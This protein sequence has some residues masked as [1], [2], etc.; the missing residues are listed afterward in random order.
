MAKSSDIIWVYR[1]WERNSWSA[2]SAERTNT[3]A[4][5]QSASR[6][7]GTKTGLVSPGDC[8]S[9]KTRKE[10]QM[11]S[12]VYRKKMRTTTVTAVFV[13]LWL[14]SQ[15]CLPGWRWAA[16]GFGDSGAAGR[17]EPS[18]SSAF[19]LL[20]L[21]W[22]RPAADNPPQICFL[23]KGTFIQ[24]RPLSGVRHVTVCMWCE[25]HNELAM[26]KY[27]WTSFFC[28]ILPLLS[29]T[30]I[31]W[32]RLTPPPSDA[33]TISS[34]TAMLEGI[35]VHRRIR[36]GL[37]P[38]RNWWP[39]NQ[40]SLHRRSTSPDRKSGGGAQEVQHLHESKIA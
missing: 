4:V 9:Y 33:A 34:V 28:A 39:K 31:S 2:K 10:G 29:V 40:S 15:M 14:N 11:F 30:S 17:G 3:L 12:F 35:F 36:V 19:H 5:S 26:K 18:N 22:D 24:T 16:A 27:R 20:R 32:L 37:A 38:F 13:V 25:Y 23:S 8:F 7:C 21:L 1:K 6:S